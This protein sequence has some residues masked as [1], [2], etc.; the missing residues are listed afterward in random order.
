MP[1][2]CTNG[3]LSS[4]LAEIE[5][6][7]IVEFFP[8]QCSPAQPAV[9]DSITSAADRGN[10]NDVEQVPVI[11]FFARQCSPA[12]P[13]LSYSLGPASDRAIQIELSTT[14]SDVTQCDKQVA[15]VVQEL[16]EPG[17]TA[18]FYPEVLENACQQDEPF[19]KLASAACQVVVFFLHGAQFRLH[20]YLYTHLIREFFHYIHYS[21]LV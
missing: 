11:E 20:Q 7:P 17:A 18:G 19:Q 4:G 21:L 1:L 15:P 10:E 16:L 8:V 13:V 9:G 14:S 5:A 6:D 3:H 2:T 12:R